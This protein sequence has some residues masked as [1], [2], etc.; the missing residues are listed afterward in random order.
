MHVTGRCHCG[1]VSF[2]AVLD[3]A[4]V[5]ICHCTDCQTLSGSPY[6]VSARVP[7]ATFR[8]KTGTLKHYVK[9]AESGNKRV[10]SFCP[11]CGTPVHAADPVDPQT[12]TLRVGTLDQRAE[13]PPRRQ[14]WRRSAM[15]WARDIGGVPGVDKQ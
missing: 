5:A 4:N 6:R 13:L 3:P 2:E 7:A 12:Y 15:S 9:T 10:H 1:Q 14:I 8:L 11:E